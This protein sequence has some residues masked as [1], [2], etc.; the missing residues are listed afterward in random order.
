MEAYAQALNFAVPLFVSL[1]IAEQLF[2][3]HLGM[4]VNRGA[5][6]IAS[7]SSGLTNVVKDV[8][9]LSIAIVSYG[10]LVDRLAIFQIDAT[11]LLYV[12]AFVAKDFAGYWIHRFE[13]EYNILWNRHVVHH[14]SEE[15]NLSCALRQTISVVISFFALFMIPAAILGVPGQVIAVIAP[16]HLFGQFW[17]H[18]RT[19]DKL[20]WLEYFLVTP[21]HHRVHHAINP[22]YI[23]KN[24]SQIFIVWDKLF[25]TFQAELPDVPPVYGVKKQPRTWN[26][27]LINFQHL[28]L[29]L[30]DAWH[31]SSWWDK[32]RLW[33]MP[34]GWRPA[35]VKT[36]YPVE[37]ISQP[38]SLEKYD[39]RLSRTL[40]Y[41]SWFQYATVGMLTLYLFNR[42]SVIGIPSIYVYGAFIVVSVYSLTTLMDKN[43]RAV[44]YELIRSLFGL[45]LIAWQGSWF[46][47]DEIIPQ[48]TWIV[49]SYLIFSLMMTLYFVRREVLQP[50]CVDT[51][52]SR[53]SH[54]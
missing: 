2:A 30:H 8:L 43:H 28:G 41:W 4:Q 23:D 13:H 12:I 19:I 54:G 46:Q 35:D 21:S 32:L 29:L 53:H 34:T 38:E 16:L 44:W 25:G 45:S 42:L 48:S 36:K 11:W 51:T 33:F 37:I 24:Y 18:T 3:R 22:Q 40:L 47:I 20:G 52:L 1:I 6:M 49:G 39:T 14:S 17:Y 31:T 27:V 26:P 5:D 10:W 7:L 50:S 15:F 9:G